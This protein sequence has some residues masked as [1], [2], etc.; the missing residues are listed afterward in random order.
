MPKKHEL[1]H[2]TVISGESQVSLTLITLY[3]I[4]QHTGAKTDMI[5][6]HP[7]IH[8]YNYT[9]CKLRTVHRSKTQWHK[10]SSWLHKRFS[11]VNTSNRSIPYHLPWT[12]EPVTISE[13][14]TNFTTPTIYHE[15]QSQWLFQN[16]RLSS[17]PLPSTVNIRANDCFRTSQIYSESSTH[18]SPKAPTLC[19]QSSSIKSLQPV[20]QKTNISLT[21][22]RIFG[23]LEHQHNAQA[24]IRV[25]FIRR[26]FI[27]KPIS[28]WLCSPRQQRQSFWNQGHRKHNCRKWGTCSTVWNGLK[29]RKNPWW[30]WNLTRGD[31][32]LCTYGT[33][34]WALVPKNS[35][36]HPESA[37][38]H[39]HR[40]TE[41]STWVHCHQLTIPPQTSLNDF[42]NR[43]VLTSQ[44]CTRPILI[45]THVHRWDLAHTRWSGQY[46][47]MLPKM[48]ISLCVVVV[49]KQLNKL[50]WQL[51]IW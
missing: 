43:S 27:F 2:L 30:R 41:C 21:N 6:K 24:V 17:Q 9:C 48:A 42:M 18:P 46:L 22:H 47:L 8:R 40:R 14:A 34:L 26:K 49:V 4:K 16:Q 28:V 31:P 32:S 19:S 7:T 23:W 37:G 35:S 13:P 3:S 15:H 11:N 51:L 5:K 39:Q 44:V 12:P 1:A 33:L 25:L 36:G 45:H 10:V 20:L 50:S 38:D 29:E